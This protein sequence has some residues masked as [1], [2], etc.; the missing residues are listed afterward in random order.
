MAPVLEAELGLHCVT[1][2]NLD[3][4]L[5]GTFTGEIER[6]MD[7]LAAAREKCLRAMDASGCDLAVASEGSFGPHP[8]MAVV[9]GD[10][11]L[12]V[13][14]DRRNGVELVA[15]EVSASTNF[16]AEA[17]RDE[18]R[19]LAF[20]RKAGFP[21]HAMILR[22]SRDGA[23][24]IHKGITDEARLLDAFR[25]LRVNSEE[26]W[27]ETDMRAMHNPTRLAVI[28]EATRK[29][30]A[31]ARS[32]CPQCAMPGFTVTDV[33]RGL[34]C[35]L[36]GLPTRGASRHVSRCRYCDCTRDL[37]FPEGKTTQDPMY[38]EFCN[39]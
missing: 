13:M 16:A 14:V 18:A 39:P 3:T 2:S 29:L 19:L 9:P 22:K 5:L 8:L 17:V 21:E 1:C 26:V 6:T 11:E 36:C 23:G 20:A 35:E 27:V 24:Q 15:R 37:E 7:P 10:D 38:C 25:Q 30:A 34:P 33:I 32:R 12:L 4:D 28:A 31:L